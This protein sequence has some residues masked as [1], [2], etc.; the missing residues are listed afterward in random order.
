MAALA[1]RDVMSGR[2]RS[3][4]GLV[5]IVAGEA[6]HLA[7][8]K[9]RRHAQAISGVRDL[10]P[11]AFPSRAIK[12]NL[13]VAERFSWPIGIDRA[14]IAANLV[15]HQAAA[16]LQMTLHADF[17][18]PVAGEPRWV[19]DRLPY[20]F[21]RSICVESRANVGAA[22]TMAPLAIDPFRN[23]FGEHRQAGVSALRETSFE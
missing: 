11:I 23:F 22:R 18:L 2:G 10:K 12:V 6:R 20:L 19:H 1:H 14:V 21:P 15:W 13:V 8:S 17:K 4:V 7:R 3:A 9:T 5:R 16:G